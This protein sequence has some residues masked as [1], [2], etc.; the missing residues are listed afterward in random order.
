MPTATPVARTFTFTAIA[1]SY[2]LSSQSNAK[3]GTS[4]TLRV[5]LSP[6]AR[7]YLRFNVQGLVDPVTSATLYVYATSTSSSGYQVAESD[8]SWTEAGLTYNNAP[9]VG[10]PMSS[11]GAIGK[12]TW[13]MAAIPILIVKN[14]P[15]NLAMVTNQDI[16]MR[17]VSREGSQKPKLVVTTGIQAA[18]A[19]AAAAAS[20]AAIAGD[21]AG[22]TA[23]DS[24]SDSDGDGL[25]DAD[26][27][28][29]GA[30]RDNPDSDGDG[31]PDLWEIERGLNP[32]LGTGADGAEGD[33]D[34]DGVANLVEFKEGSPRW[35]DPAA[36]SDQLYLPLIDR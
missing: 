21:T 33:P 9:A 5:D 29:Y 25:N 4:K 10:P 20:A 19:Q 24:A 30:D 6:I 12:N 8:N 36:S 15:V 3:Y 28:R 32:Q 11:S 18:S 35:E 17:F 34:G 23:G 31:L 1:D 7:T 26:E 2:V 14:G 13:T 22:D 16:D 27:S